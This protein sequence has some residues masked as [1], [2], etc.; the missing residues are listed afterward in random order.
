MLATLNMQ[1]F[2]VQKATGDMAMYMDADIELIN[3]TWFRQMVL[4]L[5]ENKEIVG[6]F[7][8]YY[9]RNGDNAFRRYMCLILYKETGYFNS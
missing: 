1:R 7:T 6:S 9:S 3:R 5:V 4:P 2:R 8:R